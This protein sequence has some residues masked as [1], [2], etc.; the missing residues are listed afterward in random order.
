MLI[1]GVGATRRA[2]RDQL[3]ARIWVDAPRELRL[4]RG[5]DR[6]G[7]HML[8]FWRWWM[9][10]EDT[11]VSDE[12]PDLA[13]DVCVDGAPTVGHDPQSQWVQ[14]VAVTG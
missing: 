5:V 14:L 1:E 13:A 12:R 4:R 2:W 11:Y 6:D 9:A 10:A 8:E 7:V 3:V